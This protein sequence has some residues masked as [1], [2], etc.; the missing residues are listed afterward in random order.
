MKKYLPGVKGR[1]QWGIASYPIAGMNVAALEVRRDV[2][3]RSVTH[4]GLVRKSVLPRARQVPEK[5]G[6]A[7][8]ALK[9][10]T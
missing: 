5:A 6:F 3:S 9:P 10:S 7:S 1:V 2:C 4:G 8:I